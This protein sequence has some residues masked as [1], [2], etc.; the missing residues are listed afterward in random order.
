MLEIIRL[1]LPIYLLIAVGFAIIRTGYAGGEDLRGA[2]RLVI[3]LFLPIMIFSSIAGTGTDTQSHMRVYLIYTLGSVLSY[4]IGYMTARLAGKDHG[5][6]AFEAMGC[7]CS[8]SAF[9]GLPIITVAYGPQVALEIFTVALLVENV[10]IIPLAI[11]IIETDSGLTWRKI[12]RLLGGMARNPL[13]LAAVAGLIW[14][15]SGLEIPQVFARAIALLAP[16]A[17]PVAL[18]SVGGSVAE[19]SLHAFRWGVA[20]IVI[21]KLVGHPVSVALICLVFARDMPQLAG[22]LI[23]NAALPMMASY[24]LFGQRFQR[25]DVA[26]TSLI[27]ATVLSFVTLMSLLWLLGSQL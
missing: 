9:F 1:I 4:A 3:R 12:K 24:M 11:A 2:G 18:L 14:R 16:V 23:L 8:N 25:E 6:G 20:R 15:T 22:G 10:L 21:C 27:A 5:V 26:A 17:A 13:L 19:L 7:S